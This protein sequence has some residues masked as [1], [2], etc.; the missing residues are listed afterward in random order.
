MATEEK[1]YTT[2]EILELREK[3]IQ[4]LKTAIAGTISSLVS[5]LTDQERVMSRLCDH[6]KEIQEKTGSEPDQAPKYA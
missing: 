1:E 4:I 6:L 3:Q 5:Y 2:E